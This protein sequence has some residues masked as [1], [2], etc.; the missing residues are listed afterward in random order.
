MQYLQGHALSSLI[1]RHVEERLSQVA[2]TQAGQKYWYWGQ[3]VLHLLPFS[4]PCQAGALDQ[5]HQACG[6]ERKSGGISQD[7][8]GEIYLGSL[9]PRQELSRAPAGA[10]NNVQKR[11]REEGTLK[12]LLSLCSFI[13]LFTSHSL[14]VYYTVG[15]KTD[16]GNTETAQIPSLPSKSLQ[17]NSKREVS[18]SPSVL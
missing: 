3:N 17:L 18:A 11:V 10:W 4:R 9:T 13:H 6:V 1:P 2:Q 8:S 14:S 5:S 15:T 16:G 12:P 7:Y